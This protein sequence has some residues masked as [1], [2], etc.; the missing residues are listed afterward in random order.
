MQDPIVAAISVETLIFS[1]G[2]AFHKLNEERHQMAQS[3]S[4][5]REIG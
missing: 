4:N 2:D 3:Q 1:P 5:Q